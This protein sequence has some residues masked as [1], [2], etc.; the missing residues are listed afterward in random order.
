MAVTSPLGF[1]NYEATRRATV[2]SKLFDRFPHQYTLHFLGTPEIVHFG[3]RY[4]R[5]LNL[6][7]SFAK[8]GSGIS[9]L[10]ELFLKH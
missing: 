1:I 2:Y 4:T 6:V 10:Q 8:L 5:L 7:S 3:I 9:Y